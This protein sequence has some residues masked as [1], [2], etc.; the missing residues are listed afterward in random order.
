[1]CALDSEVFFVRERA[2]V[3]EVLDEVPARNGFGRETFGNVASRLQCAAPAAILTT[4]QR[5]QTPGRTRATSKAP[6]VLVHLV[7]A[8][9]C[10]A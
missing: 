8:A 2:E 5:C 4:E 3:T 7:R 6:T 1:M 10:A 9:A